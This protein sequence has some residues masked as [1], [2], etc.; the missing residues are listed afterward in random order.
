MVSTGIAATDDCLAIFKK[1]QVG[2]N[3]HFIIY[4]I[5]DKKRIVVDC[6]SDSKDND[7]DWDSFVDR[8]METGEPRYAAVDFHFE[9]HEGNEKTVLLFCCFGS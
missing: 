4:K 6:S 7:W 5:E 3:Y 2:S 8:V 1:L 9:N